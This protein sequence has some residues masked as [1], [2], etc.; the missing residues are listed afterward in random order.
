MVYQNIIESCYYFDYKTY[1]FYF[2]SLL[3]KKRFVN[4][5]DEFVLDENLK[6][7]NKYGVKI[8]L[9]NYLIIVLYKKIEKRG[10]R[11]YNK[12]EL[13]EENLNFII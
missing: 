7:S 10:F 5:I 3:N 13:I 4:R 6:N 9:T 8:D 1:R 12:D 11:V 2:S